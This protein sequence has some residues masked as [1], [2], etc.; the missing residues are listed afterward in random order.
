MQLTERLHKYDPLI[1]DLRYHT[2]IFMA[3]PWKE[4]FREDEERKHSF[5]TAVV[6]YERLSTCHIDYGYH[7]IRNS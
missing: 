7:T 1:Q 2:T 5:E 6:E 4:I 3:P